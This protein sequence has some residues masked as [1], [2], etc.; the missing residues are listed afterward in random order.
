VEQW[1]NVHDDDHPENK[2]GTTNT[3]NDF[4]EKRASTIPDEPISEQQIYVNLQPASNNP[5][6]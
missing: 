5:N 4:L 3:F 6:A 1:L 2:A